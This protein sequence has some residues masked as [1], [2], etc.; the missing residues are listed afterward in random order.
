[1]EKC[2]VLFEVGTEFSNIIYMDVVLHGDKPNVHSLTP[3]WWYSEC[4]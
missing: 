3:R 4:K 1:M 2:C